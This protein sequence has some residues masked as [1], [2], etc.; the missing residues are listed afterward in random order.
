MEAKRFRFGL[1][2]FDASSGEL[3]REGVVVRLQAQPARVLSLL[4]SRAGAV[5]SREELR[6]VIWG[7]ET[8]VDFERGLN[9]CIA[10]IRT[11][12][13]D[14]TNSPRFIRT[15]P[16]LGYQ[17]ISHV[18]LVPDPPPPQVA[19]QVIVQPAHSSYLSWRTLILVAVA[20]I[21]FAATVAFA[22]Y[23][24]R[25]LP[26]HPAPLVVAI[27]RFDNETDDPAVSHFSDGL[28]DN[29]VEQ[30]TGMSQDRFRVIGNASVLR[31]P[32][33]QRNLEAIATSL[34]ARFII[35]GQVQRNGSQTRVLAHLIRM[36]E[37]THVWVVRLDKS[38]DDQLA[39]ES[40][41]AE[42]IARE[43]SG[44]LVDSAALGDLHSSL[45]NR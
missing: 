2:V 8:F 21:I 38:L 39:F 31:Q 9:V 6:K 44:R 37:Q 35:L 27:V 24:A 41:A 22:V 11:A 14:D 40:S 7:G 4:I 30:M 23:R 29:L 13:G 5:V 32:R 20:G 36:P 17:F 10:H 3:R 12:L 45:T 25:V 42:Q 26:S 18:E 43:F 1:F 15:V 16:R 19:E 33:D 28:T 34:H